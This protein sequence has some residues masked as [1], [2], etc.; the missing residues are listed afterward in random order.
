[1]RDKPELPEQRVVGLMS[2]TSCDGIDGVLARLTLRSG[3]LDWQVLERRHLD[4]PVDLR[5]RLLKA[6]RVET[7]D[8]SLLTQLHAQLGQLNAEL[9]S[10]FHAADLIALAGQT[11][12]HIPRVDSERDWHT[13]STLQLGEAAYVV[14]RTGT[15]VISD[16]RQA[17]LAAGGEGAP[18]VAFGDW[19][20]YRRPGERRAVHNLGGISN[21]TYLPGGEDAAS[22]TA[23]DTGPGNCLIDDAAAKHLGK[24]YDEGGQAAARGTVRKEVLESLLGHPYFA[25]APPKTTGRET[26]ELRAFAGE[27]TGL[28]AE[29]AIATLSALTAESVARAYREHL[30]PRGLDEILLAGG[31]AANPTLVKMLRER[32]PA[33]VRTFEEHGWDSRD[34]E[35]LAFAVMAYFGYH[36]L[37]NTLPQATGARHP[38]IAG[39]LSRR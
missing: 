23:F 30:S 15:P 34:R 11:V 24:P 12:Y 20:L 21:V 19:H 10:S 31:G 22:V 2:G 37:T 4:Y 35:A 13:V 36:G 6:L 14:E 16:F 7:S 39:K 5:Q 25:L 1:M 29:D 3:Q 32:L 17:D 26:F 8:V 27:L 9:A 18:L 28:S 33:C 38:V